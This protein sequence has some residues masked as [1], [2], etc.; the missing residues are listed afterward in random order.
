MENLNE[1]QA[2]C[3]HA[4][5]VAYENQGVIQ[6]A[7]AMN[8]HYSNDAEAGED[9]GDSTDDDDV[10]DEYEEN[11][12]GHKRKIDFHGAYEAQQEHLRPLVEWQMCS[13]AEIK[14]GM[15]RAP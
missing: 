10:C 15:Y 5:L 4:A 3:E 7:V 13:N 1:W 14:E 8:A 6:A 2:Q 12:A 11:Q 9:E